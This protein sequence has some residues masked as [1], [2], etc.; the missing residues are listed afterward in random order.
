MQRVLVLDKNKQPL[1]PCHPARARELL[2]KGRAAVFRRFPFTI[3]LQDREG[4]EVQE[5]QF[6]VDPG[7]K[8]TG[9]ALVAQFQRGQRVIWAAELTH[10]GRKI[11]DNLLSRRQLRR[12][13]RSRKTR[14][15]PPRFDNRCRPAGWLP[16]SLQSRVDNILTWLVRLYRFAPITHLALEL[17]RF[18]TQKLQN[19]EIS[20]VE[21][22]QGELLGYEVREYLLEKWGRKCAYCGAKNVPLEVEH[23]VPKIRG[24]SNRVSNLTLAC[25]PCNQKKGSQTAAEFGFPNIQAQAKKP[26]GDAAAVNAT[27]WTLWRELNASGLPLEVGTGGRT[28]YNRSRQGYPKTHWLDAVCVGES[29]ENVFVP[30]TLQALAIKAMGRG[31]RQMCRVDKFGFPRTK[32]KQ[33][34]RVQGFQTG[35]I[36]KAIVPKGKNEGTHVGRV[37]V[38]ASGSF[39]IRT[40]QETVQGIGYK[41]CQLTQRIDGYA[42]S[43]GSPVDSSPRINKLHR[44]P[45]HV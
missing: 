37:A 39:N 6:K 2:K 35:D 28:K 21:Y 36:V 40:N 24:G 16:P 26:L 30:Q 7:A 11:K 41:Y 23:I 38:R 25:T 42:Y 43:F 29:G 12:G 20:G 32:A 8:T 34:K 17:V 22:Q 45:P 4:G 13:R 5:T 1:M 31:S 18:D 44:L 10:R 19:P 14:Y 3:I 27:R 15:R 9:I 33:F